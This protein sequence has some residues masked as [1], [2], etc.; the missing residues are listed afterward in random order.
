M[1][2]NLASLLALAT[3]AGSIILGGILYQ[4][5]QKGRL[6]RETITGIVAPKKEVITEASKERGLED[7]FFQGEELDSLTPLKGKISDGEAE[8]ENL[9]IYGE[10]NLK[11][12]GFEGEADNLERAGRAVYNLPNGTKVLL[13]VKEYKSEDLAAQAEI[14][15]NYGQVTDSPFMVQKGKF[16]VSTENI[17]EVLYEGEGAINSKDKKEFAKIWGD[18]V[19]RTGGE[20]N[21]TISNEGEVIHTGLNKD[22][23]SKVRDSAMEDLISSMPPNGQEDFFDYLNTENN[24]GTV[25]NSA[26][27]K[28]QNIQ[29][30]G[31]IVDEG[32]DLQNIGNLLDE[33]TEPVQPPQV[34]QPTPAQNNPSP[35]PVYENKKENKAD[36]WFKKAVDSVAKTFNNL[37]Q[38]DSKLENYLLQES[39]LKNGVTLNPYYFFDKENNI[40]NPIVMDTDKLNEEARKDLEPFNVEKIASAEYLVRNGAYSRGERELMLNVLK[41]RNKKDINKFLA[42]KKNEMEYCPFFIKDK[43]VSIINPGVEEVYAL[44]GYSEEQE[45]IYTNLIWDYVKRTGMKVQLAGK[46]K[47]A[48]EE[49][50]KRMDEINQKNEIMLERLK[51][52]Y[53]E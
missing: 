43:I 47:A 28:L 18:Y 5:Y 32:T 4:N 9:R 29:E 40:S 1:G 39:E 12:A 8:F 35:A 2:K 31:G 44:G 46:N 13:T 34:A 22:L 16:L 27:S 24:Q 30:T 51:N 10:D 21:L 19:K 15:K 23:A 37:T 53:G 33:K 26:N 17:S 38:G 25:S 50:F 52:I 45:I 36:S 11:E 14:S 41:F 6:A 7:Y 49:L 48:T 3:V 20:P 42:A